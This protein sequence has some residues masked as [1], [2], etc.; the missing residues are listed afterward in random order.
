MTSAEG[1][2]V[3]S[4]YAD[5]SGRRVVASAESVGAVLAV[6]RGRR[7]S[8][9]APTIRFVHR[10]DRVRRP[11]SVL[12]ED[13]R[14]LRIT[15]RVPLDMPYGYHRLLGGAR[16]PLL[17]CSP[18]R[19]HLP[20][21][22]R[23]GGWATQVPVLRSRGSWGIGDLADLERLGGWIR[24]HGRGFVLVNPLA[25]PA[26]VQP[27]QPSPYYPTSRRFRTPLAIAV[28]RVPGA[29]LLGDR[30]DSLSRAGRALNSA[31]LID[32]DA[33]L[34]HKLQALAAIHER[35]PR[36]PGFIRFRR[37]QGRALEAFA[38]FCALAEIHGADWRR[39]PAQLRDASSSHVATEARRL[40]H[41]IGFHAWLQGIIDEQ[42]RG[43]AEAVDLVHDLPI[44]VDPGGADTW[45]DPAAYATGVTVGA[46]PDIFNPE[47]Q[48]WSLAP[49]HPWN[50]RA[51]AY[52]PLIAMLRSNLRGAA[53]LRVDH[54]M[55]LFRLYWI[56]QGNSPRD[57]VYVTYAVDE[58]LD[59]VALESH[60]AGAWVVGEDLGTVG[61]GVREEMARRSILSYRLLL[62]EEGGASQLP[63]QAMSALTTHDLPTLAGLWSGRD[64]EMRASAGLEVDA[65]ATAQVRERLRR[66][67]GDAWSRSPEDAVAS[68]YAALAAS[69]SMLAVATLEDA[70]L[71]ERRPNMPGTA[72]DAWPN[73]SQPLPGSLEQVLRLPL[74]GRLATLMG[75]RPPLPISQPAV[76][77][78]PPAP[79]RGRPAASR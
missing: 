37:G 75:S 60:R 41:R 67:A 27:V 70:A 72:T 21:D 66:V 13:N 36:P 77:A 55:G 44:G 26:P 16:P 58:I 50:L 24:S 32:R 49:F 12:T 76:P 10:G 2:G 68:L 19:C 56:P 52:A 48:D 63:V 4:A 20:D 73:W 25:A 15:G 40:R 3:V 23:L 6:L 61:P 79:R 78:P 43:A 47:G 31:V 8:R 28:E 53:G 9:P 69:P 14:E 46:P 38:T 42:L 30:L 62:F 51:A 11:L 45:C 64:D 39:W 65:A 5:T 57:G 74:A 54:V 34:T 29:T 7:R 22:L 33:V 17:V 18:G 1:W 35:S 71:V 59:I